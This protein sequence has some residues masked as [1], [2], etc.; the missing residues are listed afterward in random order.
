VVAER[1]EEV[2]M[3]GAICLL[4]SIV[5]VVGF[6]VLQDSIT[7]KYVKIPVL[8]GF[9]AARKN[10]KTGVWQINRGINTYQDTWVVATEKEAAE[11]EL[12]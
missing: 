5:I 9:R 6:F 4:V 3:I 10:R 7:Y 8:G 11:L 2:L 1:S 12:L